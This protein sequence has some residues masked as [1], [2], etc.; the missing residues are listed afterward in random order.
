MTTRAQLARL[1]DVAERALDS[2]G[3]DDRTPR[4][5]L[6]Q[7]EVNTSEDS[8]ILEL[9]VTD[10]VPEDAMRLVDRLRG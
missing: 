6:D 4:D 1:P 5:F 3:I 2:V 9:V 7:S 10:A 8:D